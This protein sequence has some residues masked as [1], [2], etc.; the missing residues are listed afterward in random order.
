[1]LKAKLLGLHIRSTRAFW[2]LSNALTLVVAFAISEN[3][4]AEY[5]LRAD[6][7]ALQELQTMFAPFAKVS[8]NQ[9]LQL[10]KSNNSQ[11]LE[12]QASLSQYLISTD[13]IL[14]PIPESPHH[15]QEIRE[16]N[17]RPQL[18]ENPMM[19]QTAL[20]VISHELIKEA[21][22]CK[23]IV[24]AIRFMGDGVNG[25]TLPG[26]DPEGNLLLI[27]HMFFSYAYQENH[28]MLP[29]QRELEMAGIERIGLDTGYHDLE[30]RQAL[31]KLARY[32][33]R[34]EDYDFDYR[35]EYISG[36]FGMSKGVQDNFSKTLRL[37]NTPVAVTISY[38]YPHRPG[39]FLHSWSEFAN[40]AQQERVGTSQ[41]VIR[42]YNDLARPYL[43]E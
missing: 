18:F 19:M 8:F 11:L 12:A 32:Y 34:N 22:A 14:A 25:K 42:R 28:A 5:K 35:R 20:E 16:M 10:K 27:T 1:M 2:V 33:F 26:I 36:F 24:K 15:T 39:Q 23:I 30:T 31:T 4:S 13:D 3:A 29:C 38:R 43:G 40:P 17:G 9:Y 41:D 7:G 6:T 37:Q 21:P